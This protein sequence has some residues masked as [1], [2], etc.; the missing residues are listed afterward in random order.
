LVLCAFADGVNQI[1]PMIIFHG[2]PTNN[3]K[4]FHEERKRYHPGVIVEFNDLFLKYIQLYLI[5]TLEERPSLFALDLCSSHKTPAV[6]DSLHREKIMPSLIPAG[7]TSLVQ[8]LDVLINKSPK[9][10]IRGF[11]DE[12]IRECESADD[13]EKWTVGDRRVFTTNCVGDAW[14]KF[15]VENR[16]L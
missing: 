1:P 3:T 13:F 12:A 9:E 6:L 14:Y 2:S 8:P 15:C 10:L 11:K 7:C 5:P 4:P 16:R